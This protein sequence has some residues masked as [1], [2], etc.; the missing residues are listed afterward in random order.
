MN[1]AQE[2]APVNSP[3]RRSVHVAETP[4]P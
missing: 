3:L 4:A 1:A 2:I